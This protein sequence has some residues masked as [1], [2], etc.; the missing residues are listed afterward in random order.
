MTVQKLIGLPSRVVMTSHK[1]IGLMPSD[2]P[3]INW[4]DIQRWMIVHTSIGLRFRV[5]DDYPP[6][7]C[8]D[9]WSCDDCPQ[10]S[11]N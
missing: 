7:N 11:A 2:C 4:I 3:Q 5:V 9:I 10:M 1:S 8:I 6:I